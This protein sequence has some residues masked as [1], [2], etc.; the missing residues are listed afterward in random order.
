MS[1]TQTKISI[2]RNGVWAGSGRIDKDGEIV[3]CAAVL[4]PTQDDSDDTYES[5]Q[6]A[7]DSEPQD[8]GRY[9]GTGSIERPDGTYSWEIV[10]V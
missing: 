9:S 7:I 10:E 3:D 2:F 4:G 5:I 8:E 1:A 6:D